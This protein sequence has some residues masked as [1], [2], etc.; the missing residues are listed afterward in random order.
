MRFWAAIA[1]LGSIPWGLPALGQCTAEVG[2]TYLVSDRY[3][4]AET[5]NDQLI[6]AN[7]NG[8]V[9]KSMTS[10]NLDSV[11]VVSIPG[12]ITALAAGGDRVFAMAYDLGVFFLEY[13]PGQILPEQDSFLSVPGARAL[14]V[15]DDFLF[16]AADDVFRVFRF[17]AD[18]SAKEVDALPLPAPL[19]KVEA[20]PY[21]VFGHM[22]NGGIVVTPFDQGGFSGSLRI[23]SIGDDD[24]FYDMALHGDEVILDAPSGIKWAQFSPDG[25][26]AQFGSYLDNQGGQI[27]VGMALGGNRLYVRYATRFDVYSIVEGLPLVL[28][29]ST[30]IDLTEIRIP[31]MFGF[32]DN[33]VLLNV[34]SNSRTWSVAQFRISGDAL[35]QQAILPSGTARIDGVAQVGNQ[36]VF[37]IGN[38]LYFQ[39][40][41]E[42]G[43]LGNPID[44]NQFTLPNPIL[45]LADDDTH[46]Y[47]TTSDP[48]SGA[49]LLITLQPNASGNLIRQSEEQFLGTLTDLRESEG[50]LSFLQYYRDAEA[51]RY[52]IHVRP[53][54]GSDM[55]PIQIEEELPIGSANPFR[56]IVVAGSRLFYHD[57]QEILS[58]DLDQGGNINV[59]RSPAFPDGI[60][61]MAAS[62]DLLWIET[63][64]GLRVYRRWEGRLSEVGIYPNWTDLT[65]T[66]NGNI[67]AQ[68]RLQDI[69]G[70]NTLLAPDVD[71]L[72]VPQLELTTSSPPSYLSFM[73]DQ[74]LVSEPWSVNLYDVACP[75]LDY[76]YLMPYDPDYLLEVNTDLAARTII[77]VAVFDA[78]N[79]VIGLQMLSR[80]SMARVNGMAMASWF[81]DY[82]VQHIPV[83]LMLRCSEP[84]SPIVSGTTRVSHHPFGYRVPL[85]ETGTITATHVPSLLNGWDTQLHLRVFDWQDAVRVDAIDPIGN[86]CILQMKPPETLVADVT[87]FFEPPTTWFDLEGEHE[88]TSLSGFLLF[89]HPYLQ[90]ATAVPLVHQPSVVL[91]VPHLI[92]QPQSWWTGLALTNPNPH[93][94][95]LR[96]LGYDRRG[97]ISVDR[98]TDIPADGQFVTIVE[99]WLRISFSGI[100]VRW[101]TLVAEAPIFGVIL[102]G[103]FGSTLLGGMSLPDESESSTELDFPGIQST[104]EDWTTVI[105]TNRETFEDELVFWAID[106]Q[107]QVLDT[108]QASIGP[109]G[110]LTMR[111]TDLFDLDSGYGDADIKTI[112]VTGTRDLIG[113]VFRGDREERHLEAYPALPR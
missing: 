70:L 20:N 60:S 103:K 61:R 108:V 46:L 89:T 13:R 58:R 95:R 29:A 38:T 66:D 5:A 93:P 41:V 90:Y 27:I 97:E 86:R 2:S 18:G 12:D 39:D 25:D 110:T 15:H 31:R 23:M 79:R 52:I 98:S 1:L 88:D 68:N 73:E 83:S 77:Q 8:L 99:N 44:M 100:E 43:P 72:I 51:D 19:K 40:T 81:I 106:G 109:K 87:D 56:D 50:W 63:P 111:T 96:A 80:E 113:M 76:V 28:Q 32:Q 30:Q 101:M 78:A 55:A 9:F 105:V 67:L 71:D 26:V 11:G 75:P 37:G 34:S 64:H 24:A 92:D 57:G 7:R 112:R 45:E 4:D 14:A 94:V 59:I 74:L 3:L 85:A 62:H 107:G 102:Y 16:V 35:V 21:L 33:L 10:P 6:L 91:L 48:D 53:L 54:S 84:L 104:E 42:E 69:P 65:L 47:V 22:E 36:V 49:A 17:A 82:N